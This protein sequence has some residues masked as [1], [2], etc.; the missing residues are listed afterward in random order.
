MTSRTHASVARWIDRTLDAARVDECVVIV[1]EHTQANLRWANSRLSTNG[2]MRER[3]GT[4]IAIHHAPNGTAAVVRNGD[5]ADADALLGLLRAAEAGVRHAAPA[6]DAMPLVD[7]GVDIDFAAPATRTEI[8]VLGDFA[9]G[10]GE[11]FATGD[12]LL[13]GF[14]EH[15]VTT[16]WLA[17]TAGTRRRF[18][19]PLGRVELNAKNPDLVN[20]AWVGQR[21]ED[22]CDVDPAAL[23]A[24]TMRRL[25]WGRRRIEL[26]PGAYETLLPPG[27]V[28][29]LMISAYWAMSARDAAEGR[30]AYAGP[31]GTTRIGERLSKQ[32]LHLVADPKLS[33]MRCPSFAVVRAGAG[34]EMSVFDN[35]A[36]V[37]PSEWLRDGVLNDLVRTRNVAEEQ[38]AR[39]AFP[40]ANLE[41]DGGGTATLDEMIAGTRHGLLLTSLWYI[42]EVDPQR[43]LLTGLTRDGVYLIEDGAVVGAV[44]NFRFNESPL[45]L[46]GRISEVG[47]TMPTLCREWNDWFTLTRMP[48]LRVGDFHMSTVS[49]AH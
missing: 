1:D 3:T 34:G 4:V 36:P 27:A 46:L 15:Q 22:F 9:T 24:E 45:E 25:E 20:S 12:A 5:V 7:G 28:A 6:E 35:G 41:L 23:L 18:V 11:A 40:V 44:N 37:G 30:N 13:F 39:F 14:A 19:Q 42:R 38:G 17:T 26:P 21:T 33:A 47:R 31:G 43:L 16:T 2:Q 49:Q 10:L 8:G 48:P 32:P 29:D